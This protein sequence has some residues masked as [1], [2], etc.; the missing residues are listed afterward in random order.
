MTFNIIKEEKENAYKRV[1]HFLL[2]WVSMVFTMML[3]IR[4]TD[5]LYLQIVWLS[6]AVSIEL[7]KNYLIK[8]IKK[9]YKT[10]FWLFVVGNVLLYLIL[11]TISGV[12][13]YG[14]V[15]LTLEEQ[16]LYVN[17]MNI[18]SNNLQFSINQLDKKIE[19]LNRSA[20]ASV[21]EKEKM[22][23]AEDIF[24]SGQIKLTADTK[25]AEQ[26]MEALL[27][28]RTTL[29]DSLQVESKSINS[30]SKDVFTLIGEDLGIPGM[31]VLFW[32]FIILIFVLEIT[33]FATTEGFSVK[34]KKELTEEELVFQYIDGLEKDNSVVLNSDINISE[35]T[36]I[37][38]KDCK[39]YRA[40]LKELKWRGKALVSANN[41]ANFNNSSMKR[42]V[43][44]YFNKGDN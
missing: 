39:R 23:E 35:S 22:N 4:F 3:F 31:V 21:S 34:A 15:K 24:Y 41:R 14:A 16:E 27:K 12:C 1:A 43:K 20:D 8:R 13:T 18:S 7:T 6:L 33:L 42:V 37:S 2:F 28:E 11:A 32:I 30:I 10:V 9:M 5:N 29:T 44:E 25:L 26:E 38:K 40:L 17:K 19:R 36:G